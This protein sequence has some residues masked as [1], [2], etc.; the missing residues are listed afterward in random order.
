MIQNSF[1]ITSESASQ[2]SISSSTQP[3]RVVRASSGCSV[4]FVIMT[5]TRPSRE[6]AQSRAFE[7]TDEERVPR[8]LDRPR[9]VSNQESDSSAS[10]SR[11]RVVPNAS[12]S[13]KSE[14]TQ[15]GGSSVNKAPSCKSLMPARPSHTVTVTH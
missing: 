4:W 13:S 3:G 10:A 7:S 14:T 5:R 12:T 9:G 2:N 1:V 6:A 11:D 15:R 8:V